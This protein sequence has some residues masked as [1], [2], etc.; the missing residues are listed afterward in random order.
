MQTVDLSLL[1]ELTAIKEEPCISLYMKTHRRHPENTVD[2]I[3]FKKLYKKTLNYIQEHHFVDHEALLL[4]LEHLI[5]D[6]IFWDNNDRGLAIFC[7]S[8]GTK[9]L[10]L[11]K[12]VGEI[13]CV[14]YS[15][16]VKP[17]FN[18]YNENQPYYLLALGLDNVRFY[19]GNKYHLEEID[20]TDKIPKDME[21]AL[22]HELTENH[23]HG[24]AVQG[25]GLH[26][27][28]EKSQE[29]DI[30]MDRFFRKVD[31]AVQENFNITK[32]KPLLL[33]TL[34][35]HQSHFLR[36]SKSTNLVSLPIRI[37]PHA[38]SKE[39]LL[40]KVQ[41]NMDQHA[42]SEKKMLLERYQLAVGENLSST[43]LQG[44]VQ[45]ALDGK[46][47]VLVI[48]NDRSISGTID[49][50]KRNVG[51]KQ[52]FHTDVINELSCL[53]FEQGGHVVVLDREEMPTET[54]AFTINRY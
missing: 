7:S 9:I 4:P 37:N 10:R 19:Q 45:D 14:A 42:E 53:V 20:I 18:F 1:K 48:E 46:I 28:M 8:H 6:K 22:G 3:T 44:V 11:P 21:E 30:D 25:T 52:P 17:L 29:E 38:L 51:Q 50:E 36:L 43:E 26:G 13:S 27:Y 24:S 23:L 33:A 54:G 5:D 34:P 35:E 32:A 41:E 12:E 49:V 39:E 2:P 47:D 16:C 40:K 15:F 31:R